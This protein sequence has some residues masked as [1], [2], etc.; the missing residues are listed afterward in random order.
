MRCLLCCWVAATLSLQAAVA[1]R[2]L[3]WTAPPPPLSLGQR[4]R[5]WTWDPGYTRLGASPFAVPRDVRLTGT[6]VAY[7]PLDSVRVARTGPAALFSMTPE[8]T[9]YWSSVAQIDVPNGRNTLGGAAGG[10]AGAFGVALLASVVAKAFGCD[11]GNNCPN[12][13]R[14]TAQVSL[15]TVP[16][17]AVYGFFSTRWKRVY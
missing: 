11:V 9:V 15:V 5:V 12:V 6:L 2:R 3:P 13:W 16:G 7:S 1:Q 10:L 4:V 8:R 14:T 17:G